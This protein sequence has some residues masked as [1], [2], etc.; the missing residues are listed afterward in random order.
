MN[1]MRRVFT[2]AALAGAKRWTF[3]PPTAGEGADEPFRTV[4]VPVVFN[5]T[6]VGSLPGYG[7]WDSCVPGPRQRA[8]WLSDT[9]PTFARTRCPVAACS[10]S[11][12]A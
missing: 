11:S 7:E 3:Q 9:D 5:I 8:P 4:R 1:R 2:T 10:R 12:A 6:G